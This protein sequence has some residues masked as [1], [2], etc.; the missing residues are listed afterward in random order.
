MACT[1][2]NCNCWDI[3]VE[4]LNGEYPKHGYPCLDKSSDDLLMA[5][6]QKEEKLKQVE[7]IDIEKIKAAVNVSKENKQHKE[8]KEE[9]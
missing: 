8:P 3:E 4:R 9:Q 5:K 2:P 7:P 6:K 1:K